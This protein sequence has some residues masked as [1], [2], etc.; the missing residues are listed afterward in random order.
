MTTTAA[1]GT[2]RIAGA[3]YRLPG[4][5]RR[6]DYE[7][8]QELRNFLLQSFWTEEGVENALQN[9]MRLTR[10]LAEERVDRPR[11]QWA[12]VARGLMVSL[13]PQEAASVALALARQMRPRWSMRQHLWLCQEEHFQR[14]GGDP[15]DRVLTLQKAKAFNQILDRMTIREEIEGREVYRAA[16]PEMTLK[17]K[18]HFAAAF[19]RRLKNGRHVG[20]EFATVAVI[21]GAA[22]RIIKDKD[23][24]T[25]VF[26][27]FLLRAEKERGEFKKT[28]KCSPWRR[29]YVQENSVRTYWQDLKEVGAGNPHGVGVL[30]SNG[31]GCTYSGYGVDANCEWYGGG[32]RSQM[33]AHP[34]L[35][36]AVQFRHN[37]NGGCSVTVRLW[38][39]RPNHCRGRRHGMTGP[40]LRALG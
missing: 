2:A 36:M 35:V 15:D 18:Q 30:L 22:S 11:P 25:L 34:P 9:V 26:D 7:A 29:S 16:T 17:G 39:D 14:T 37:D 19:P 4:H 23:V 24:P 31:D 33:P 5:P 32:W 12:H 28:L 40:M 13:R 8:E 20:W 21:R 3:Q 27:P 1:I 6:W 38:A 10:R